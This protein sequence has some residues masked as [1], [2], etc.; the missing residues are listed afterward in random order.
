M[1][2]RGPWGPCNL[3]P[4]PCGLTLAFSAENPPTPVRLF[5][6]RQVNMFREGVGVFKARTHSG[7]CGMGAEMSTVPGGGGQSVLPN[8]SQPPLGE[9]RL[10]L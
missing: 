3:M 2:G 8:V 5:R 10:D 9:K 1:R 6:A 7:E 4:L